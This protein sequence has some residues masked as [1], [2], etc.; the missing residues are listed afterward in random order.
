MM[1]TQLRPEEIKQIIE[2]KHPSPHSIL[3]NHKLGNGGSE[4][5]VIRA[6]LPGAARVSVVVEGGDLPRIPMEK[7]HADGLF[8]TVTSTNIC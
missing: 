3:G 8:E 2:G 7:I 4:S 5:I 6:F 1:D